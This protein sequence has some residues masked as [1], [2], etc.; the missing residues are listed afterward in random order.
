MTAPFYAD[1]WL[2]ILGGDCRD[3]LAT[4]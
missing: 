3:V 2:T 4:L 1:E